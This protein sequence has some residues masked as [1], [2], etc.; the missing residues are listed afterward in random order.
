MAPLAAEIAADAGGPAGVAAAPPSAT[1]TP[2]FSVFMST[3]TRLA[4]GARDRGNRSG[5]T[6]RTIRRGSPGPTAGLIDFTDAL[7]ADA[8]KAI[9]VIVLATFVLL[10][11]L[12]RVRAD[13]DQGADHERDLAGRLARRAWSGSSRTA[14]ASRL[15]GF[16]STGGV[17]AV[18][19][20]LVLAL[21][22]GLAMDYEVF[23][24]V[25]HQGVPSTR[26]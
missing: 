13:P 11:L 4:G 23:L 18:I 17:E 24:L 26:A 3:R 6:A 19:P 15:L 20:I 5:T 10:F 2:S 25:P 7:A 16:S 12:D 22:F 1:A 8:P 9:A 14:T 21:G